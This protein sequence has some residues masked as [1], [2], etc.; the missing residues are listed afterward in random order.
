M[1][2]Q[3]VLISHPDMFVK[4]SILLTDME[5]DS[6]T[7]SGI[8]QVSNTETLPS[9]STLI[10]FSINSYVVQL[11]IKMSS[12]TIYYRVRYSNGPWSEIV[13]K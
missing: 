3:I 9:Y 8:Y 13:L 10:V 2:E 12:P 5:V 4:R 7:L 1:A 11:F 6:A